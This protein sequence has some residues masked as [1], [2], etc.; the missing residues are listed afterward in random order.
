MAP[1]NECP[2]HIFRFHIYANVLAK[3]KEIPFY[4]ERQDFEAHGWHSA[5]VDY[6]LRS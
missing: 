1:S 5:V 6:C 2:L 4:E 3:T